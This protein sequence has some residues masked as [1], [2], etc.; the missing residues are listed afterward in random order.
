MFKVRTREAPTVAPTLLE[1]LGQALENAGVV[2]CQWKG[3]W[4]R[5]RWETGAG[6]IDLLVDPAW[7]DRLEIEL[8]RLG[9]KRG[10]APPEAQFPGTGSWIGYDAERLTLAHV[11]LHRRLIVGGYWTT[12]YRL[13]MERAVLDTAVPRQPF[14]V[15][16][17]ELEFIMFV[18]RTVQRYS[19]RDILAARQPRWL[20]DTQPECT[21]LRNQVNRDVLVAR[22]AEL[23]PSVS[24][25]FFDA[26]TRSLAPKASRWT[27]LWLRRGLQQR[28]APHAS[29]PP[30]SL[31][32]RRIGRS[33]GLLPRARGLHPARG[34]RVLALLGG[35]GSGKSTCV[36]ELSRWIG[37]H[38]AVMTAHLGRPPRSL[39]TLAVGALLKVR[40]AFG[41]GGTSWLD[42]LRHVCTARDR[43]RLFTK[44]C[45]FA[46]AG[47]VALC[48]RY[49]VAQNR[50]LVGPEIPRLLER[51]PTSSALARRL[52]RAEAWYY[53]HI[54]RPDVIMV[55][56][57]EPEI[58]V[59]RKTDEPA[60]YVRARS[61]II[62]ETDW[63][64]T[65]ARVV[66]AGRTLPEVL[67][68]LKAIVWSEV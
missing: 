9:F 53:R 22:L 6:D 30:I 37:P 14:P 68:D 2:Y 52:Q 67:A 36:A 38:F 57:V 33:L 50:L 47:G 42:L 15:P 46:E 62:W 25:A 27:R 61:R 35:D 64:G 34:G 39:T 66:D 44:A 12:V 56:R 58:A 10:V 51:R 11:H 19:P 23:L 41:K 60:D 40:R 13:P 26:C 49:P 31:L 65:G 63:T 21:Y 24:V 8:G 5:T 59:R 32:V 18:L 48:E 20:A 4:K 28:L 54:T 43:Y 55:L 1:R 16:A 17:P 3:H 29:H 7:G 45:R